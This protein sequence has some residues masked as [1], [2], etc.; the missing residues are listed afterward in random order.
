MF[1]HFYNFLM[2]QNRYTNPANPY[3]SGLAGAP[4]PII[5]TNNTIKNPTGPE[6][7]FAVGEGWLTLRGL[8]SRQKP[9]R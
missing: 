8:R 7:Q 4:M 3:G 1:S 9:P 6:W 5:E 2:L